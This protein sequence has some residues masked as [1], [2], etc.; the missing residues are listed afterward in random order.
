[1][2][3]EPRGIQI[4]DLELADSLGATLV[5]IGQVHDLF[6]YPHSDA[7]DLARIGA[8]KSLEVR[9]ADRNAARNDEWQLANTQPDREGVESWIVQTPANRL[10]VISRP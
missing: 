1:M 4:A 10:G 6:Q 9:I 2:A 8:R 5:A 3:N 7:L